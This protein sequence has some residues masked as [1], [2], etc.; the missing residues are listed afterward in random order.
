[1]KVTVF[2]AA[3]LIGSL[4][5]VTEATRLDTATQVMSTIDEVSR[6]ISE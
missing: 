2:A 6:P 3:T 4:L 5:S 1:M